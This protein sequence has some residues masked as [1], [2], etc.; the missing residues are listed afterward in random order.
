MP[1]T[2]LSKEDWLLWME[3]IGGF[4][5]SAGLEAAVQAGHVRSTPD[6]SSLVS[7]VT[8]SL[9]S[10]AHSAVPYVRA[11]WQAL[12]ETGLDADTD[13][14]PTKRTDRVKNVVQKLQ[15]LDE[16]Y[17]GLTGS[18]HVARRASRTQ[19]AAFLTLLVRGFPAAHGVDVVSVFK[20]EVRASRTAGHLPICFGVVSNCLGI[21]LERT[22]H[23]F[24]FLHVRA[25]LSAAIRLNLV[26]PYQGQQLLLTLQ[27]SVESVLKKQCEIKSGVDEEIGRGAW[28]TA[29]VVDILQGL[30]DRL[31]SR[32]FNS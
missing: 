23:L 10:Y 14:L 6:G 25:I 28:Q 19:G 22:S 3:V 20:T 8:A 16:E 18:N 32:M 29:P 15:V 1:E 27:K 31:Y 2:S 17:D 7:F 11:A 26:G 21:S 4:V 12:D 13:S 24:L 30:H 9:H 5:A